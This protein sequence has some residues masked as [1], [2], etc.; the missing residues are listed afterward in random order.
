MLHE[1]P[2]EDNNFSAKDNTARYKLNDP[3]MC[4]LFGSS[5]V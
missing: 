5:T 2:K 3:P 4:P 1:P